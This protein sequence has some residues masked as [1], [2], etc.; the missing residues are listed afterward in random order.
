MSQPLPQDTIEDQILQSD[1]LSIEDAS[2]C[3]RSACIAYEPEIGSHL[4]NV[5]DYSVALARKIELDE[6]KIELLWH[7]AA[8]HDIGK[9]GIPKELIRKET[10]LSE[11]E[12]LLMQSHTTIGHGILNTGTSVFLQI[13]AEIALSHHESWD[14]TGY[15]N[16]IKGNSIPL[17]ARIVAIADVYDALRSKR[18]YKRAWDKE[19]ALQEMINLRGQKFDPELLDLFLADLP[20]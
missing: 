11:S 5:S 15:P 6:N 19:E 8:L 2:L 7:G 3:L 13:A 14:G 10:S 16:Q 18:P 20:A 4:K 17:T 9:L 1:G 12:A